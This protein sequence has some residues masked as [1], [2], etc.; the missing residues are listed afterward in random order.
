MTNYQFVEKDASELCRK[1]DLPV[2]SGRLLAASGLPEE[3]NNSYPVFF[4]L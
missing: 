2:L 4:C 1:Y 3:D